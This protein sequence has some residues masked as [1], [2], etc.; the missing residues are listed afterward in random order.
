MDLGKWVMLLQQSKGLHLQR[1]E[2]IG[3][4]NKGCPLEGVGILPLLHWC[5]AQPG[6]QNQCLEQT[7]VCLGSKVQSSPESRAAPALLSANTPCLQFPGESMGTFGIFQDQAL[8]LDLGGKKYSKWQPV[9]TFNSR[10]SYSSIRYLANA[11]GSE[12]HWEITL[13]S[14]VSCGDTF[15]LKTQVREK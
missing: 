9:T 14:Y 12:T 13:L 7:G 3:V 8:C 10:T 5:W 15:S 6:E 4:Q 11:R 2:N 1:E